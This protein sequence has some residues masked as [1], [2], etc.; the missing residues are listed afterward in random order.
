MRQ[1]LT[2][3]IFRYGKVQLK[4]PSL[5]VWCSDSLHDICGKGLK[6]EAPCDASANNICIWK[7]HSYQAVSIFQTF[8][9]FILNIQ[10]KTTYLF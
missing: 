6:V 4:K 7:N 5:L 9:C 1:K 8:K 2:L 3:F 10:A